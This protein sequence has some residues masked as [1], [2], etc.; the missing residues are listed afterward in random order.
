MS[1]HNYSYI[2]NGCTDV[3]RENTSEGEGCRKKSHFRERGLAK[4]HELIEG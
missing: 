3:I 1:K 4:R 2:K